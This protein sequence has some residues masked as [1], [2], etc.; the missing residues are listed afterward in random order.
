MTI[1]HFLHK[2]ERS[3]ANRSVPEEAASE[4]PMPPLSI[5]IFI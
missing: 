4:T 1:F 2:K 5:M 3:P